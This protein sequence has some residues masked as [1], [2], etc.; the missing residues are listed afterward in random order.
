MLKRLGGQK[1]H[2]HCLIL[3]IGLFVAAL[4][5]ISESQVDGESKAACRVLIDQYTAEGA[6]VFKTK[7]LAC[8]PTK[9]RDSA[10]MR[11]EF[12]LCD[13]CVNFESNMLTYTETLVGAESCDG[14]GPRGQ[15]ERRLP[16]LLD[17]L[18]KLRG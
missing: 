6:K 8:L 17:L 10:R 1:G 2:T 4:H 16:E 18:K 7:V 12:K 13:A 3:I 5:A 11:I 9:C 15:G 14:R